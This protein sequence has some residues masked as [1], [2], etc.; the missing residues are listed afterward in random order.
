MLTLPH[1][2]KMYISN[3]ITRGMDIMN[4]DVRIGKPGCTDWFCA[5]KT[6]RVQKIKKN[7]DFKSLWH[8]IKQTNQI[9]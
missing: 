6:I 3:C 8:Q 4:L 7:S 9:L 2:F 5:K 1:N